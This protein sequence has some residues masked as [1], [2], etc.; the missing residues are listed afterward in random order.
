M[1]R[2]KV[3]LFGG[4]SEGRELAQWL[5]TRGCEVTVCVATEYGRDL[6]PPAKG[7]TPLVG[8]LDESQMT[9][10]MRRGDY[11]CV[12]DATHPYA[13]DATKNIASAARSARLP[14][15]RFVRNGDTDGDWISAANMKQAAEICKGLTGNILLTTGSK[16]L[17]AFCAL[18]ERCFPRV[19]PDMASLA[20]CLELGYPKGNILC[21]QGPHSKALNIALIEQYNIQIMVTKASGTAGGFAEKLEAARETGCKAIVIGRPVREEAYTLPDLKAAIEQMI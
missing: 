11:A 13:A 5:F 4:T 6:L 19:L 7:V 2:M 17:S 8:R 15:L 1:T 21:M 12:I 16:E 18:N 14:M 3:L 9:A 10:E 20:R